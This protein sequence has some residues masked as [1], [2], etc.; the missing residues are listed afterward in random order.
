MK[1]I[2]EIKHL[3]RKF[4]RV[5]IELDDGEVISVMYF[6]NKGKPQIQHICLACKHNGRDGWVSYRAYKPVEEWGDI[7]N[8]IESRTMFK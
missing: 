3:Y 7:A 2:K 5:E 8:F 1:I 6:K 4:Y